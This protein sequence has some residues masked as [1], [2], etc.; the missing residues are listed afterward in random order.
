MHDH[1]CIHTHLLDIIYVIHKCRYINVN[2][3]MRIYTWFGTQLKF[4]P[5]VNS[6]NWEH[7]RML[8][9]HPAISSFFPAASWARYRLSGFHADASAA[10]HF[11]E[12]F[13][14]STLEFGGAPTDEAHLLCAAG[15]C[16]DFR[17]WEVRH[18]E[19]ELKVV[20]RFSWFF[21]AE[22]HPLCQCL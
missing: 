16:R 7:R 4:C 9:N 10:V 11:A 12:G 6:W 17:W 19:V 21:L 3:Y 18:A 2:T 15:R 22:S 5:K 1:I 20:V 14:G 8:K 13:L